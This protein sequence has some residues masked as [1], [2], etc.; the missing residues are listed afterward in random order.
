[1][2]KVL[3]GGNLNTLGN[4][5][6]FESDRSTWGF[7]DGTD[8][9]FTRSSAQASSGVYSALA[10]NPVGGLSNEAIMYCQWTGEIGKKYVVRANIRTPSG[11]PLG[12]GAEL[13]NFRES[14]SNGFYG[15]TEIDY[16]EKTITESTDAW[17]QVEIGLLADGAPLGPYYSL[18]LCAPSSTAIG[19]GQLY[20][21]QFEVYEYIDDEDPDPE[22]E[23]TPDP[24]DEVFFSRNPVVKAKAATSGWEALTNYRLYDD[25][26]VEDVA[27]SDT[28]V[29][30]LKMALPPDSDGNVM[31][32][33]REAFRGVL[34]ATPPTLNLATIDRLTDRVKRFKHFTGELQNEEVTPGTLVGSDAS[35]V[36]LGGLNKFNWPTLDFFNTYLPATKKFLSWA[37]V[38]KEV[39]R[40][41]EDYLTYYVFDATTA[42]INVLIKVYYDDATNQTDEVLTVAGALYQHLYQLPAGPQNSGALLIN[43]AKTAIK[44]ELWLTDQDD[45]V[46]SEV[47]TYII[48]AV[49]S[50]RKRFFLFLNSLSGY[51]VLRFNAQAD[52]NTEFLKEG[53]VK[54]LPYNYSALDGEKETNYASLQ[55]S[56]NYGS[57]YMSGQYA[58]AW[59]DYLKDFLLSR[60]VFDVT[61]GKRRP[62]SIAGGNFNTGAD[63]DYERA[64]RFTVLDSYENENYTPK[65]T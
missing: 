35:L 46:I 62:V 27:D 30:K 6:Q 45:E 43:P 4:N 9:T 65:S 32:Q 28:Y 23:P 64:I 3:V 7:P 52:Y 57:G 33:V 16:I 53:I 51:E 47:R 21:D 56:G 60:R 55:E 19:G 5:G 48:D 29:S 20:I 54:F 1:M 10:T 12:A 38:E 59:L 15:L 41:Q 26:R 37:P 40:L 24:V 61:D 17:V 2:A 8:F 13:I 39:D 36:L 34:N 11:N 42:E 50:P 63:Q 49:S 44:Y 18:A 58:A 22:P 25:V 31:F 14:L